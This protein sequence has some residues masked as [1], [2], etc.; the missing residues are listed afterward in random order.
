MDKTKPLHNSHNEID[1]R[2]HIVCGESAHE[3]IEFRGCGTDAE[4]KRDLDEDDEEGG[5]PAE[6]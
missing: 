3:G 2:P 4:K 6:N 1:T 5:C